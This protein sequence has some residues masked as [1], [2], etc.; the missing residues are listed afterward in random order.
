MPAHHTREEFVVDRF[1]GMHLGA[2]DIALPP[3]MPQ[4]IRNMEHTPDGGLSCLRGRSVLADLGHGLP[5]LALDTY[6]DGN[7]VE[8]LLAMCGDSLYEVDTGDGE[9][10]QLYE[11]GDDASTGTMAAVHG[12]LVA[13]NDTGLPCIWDETRETADELGHPVP[14][15]APDGVPAA[16]SNLPNETYYYVVTF[17]YPEPEAESQPGPESDGIT[18]AAGPQSIDLSN[19]P[20]G[21]S[22]CIA[23]SLY[24]RNSSETYPKH[25]YTIPNNVTT[26]YNDDIADADRGAQ[27]DDT[28]QTPPEAA[29]IAA[30]DGRLWGTADANYPLDLFWS[31]NLDAHTWD[32]P[33][34]RLRFDAAPTALC[35]TA[36]GLYVATG[37]RLYLITKSDAGVYGY[38]EV[39]GA[40]GAPGPRA[41]AAVG[42]GIAYLGHRGLRYYAGP[43]TRLSPL[44]RST[45][46]YSAPLGDVWAAVHPTYADDAT[47]A[48]V[49]D[50]LFLAFDAAGA[51][52]NDT[53]YV[54]TVA[55]T[56]DG[57]IAPLW[58][59][60]TNSRAAAVA[61]HADTGRT[62]MASAVSSAI[63]RVLIDDTYTDEAGEDVEW[64]IEWPRWDVAETMRP[65]QFYAIA[66]DGA[67]GWTVTN[68]YYEI[69]GRATTR[70]YTV[71]WEAGEQPEAALWGYYVPTGPAW[72]GF[73]WGDADWGSYVP[74][75]PAWGNFNWGETAVSLAT[76]R[77][78]LSAD[79]RGLNF[80]LRL[81]GTGQATLNRVSLRYRA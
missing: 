15:S 47:V 55:P 44:V 6:R 1:P 54:A 10:T 13:A 60:W 58:A 43:L 17:H 12:D 53:L 77:Q 51:G 57:S 56:Q 72:G 2:V 68:A 20:T 70:S 14:E 37:A 46:E 9:A 8:F 63:F 35:P 16:G 80:K 25:V 29:V 78:T 76:L 73:E 74:T 69:E 28:D 4:V 27:V 79:A 18:I 59:E 41:V 40:E 32:L 62:F 11:W 7:G 71:R 45:A 34:D 5:V 23:R 65:L 21:G 66:L 39:A 22:R 31:A 33:T 48:A 3:N 64:S 61:Y 81:V 26:T 38:E 52:A 50:R 24:R 75:G 19:I 36:T 67:L 30:W 49:G 42:S